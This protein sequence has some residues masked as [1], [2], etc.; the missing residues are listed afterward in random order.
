MRGF[1][2]R[3][4]LVAAMVVALL[5]G[6]AAA[7]HAE[8]LPRLGVSAGAVRRDGGRL[9]GWTKVRNAGAAGVAHPALVLIVS[10]SGDDRRAGRMELPRLASGSAH[11]A[12][13]DMAL[14]R[15][16]PSGR[17]RI[18]ACARPH[19]AAPGGRA[20]CRRVGTVAIGG[21]ARA[22]IHGLESAA[23][24]SSAP[25]NPIPFEADVPFELQSAAAPYWIDVPHSYDATNRTPATLLVWLHGCGGESSGDIWVVRAEEAQRWIAVAPG[26]REGGCWNPNADQALVKATLASVK[27]HFNIAPRRIVLG[28]YSSGGD[29][30]YR[31]AFYDAGDFAGVLAENTAPFRDTGS[32]EGASLAAASWKFNVVHLAHLQDTTY[33]IAEVRPETEALAAAGF[34]I[35]RIERPGHH[36]DAPGAKVEGAK[37]PGTDADLRAYLLPH[38][39]DGWTA[40]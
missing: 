26:G 18:V 6:E 3:A 40:P 11:F 39:E 31:T 16:L 13:I 20:G 23:E 21:G 5:A 15:H 8:A 28:G 32:T 22:P 17:I 9:V 25:T 36:F 24:P 12:R 30:A 10:A 37:V 2:P 14:P 34:S 29:L 1:V 33:P 7:G 19:V 27:T 35:E 4:L 38:L